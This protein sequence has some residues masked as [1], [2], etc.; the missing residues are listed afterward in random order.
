MAVL[1]VHGAATWFMIGLIW[2]IQTVHYPLFR[3]VGAADFA[4]YEAEHTRRM[5]A[6]LILPAVAEIVT[7]ALL[8]WERPPA[9]DLWMVIV[10]GAVLAVTWIMTALVH[11][12]LHA[13]L[14]KDRNPALI[15]SLVRSNWW[16]TAAWTVRGGFVAVMLATSV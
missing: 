1:L 4:R 13:R 8:V 12:P 11:A 3:R 14:S 2:T 9:V 7:G 10:A 6:L 15:E 5:G 16:R